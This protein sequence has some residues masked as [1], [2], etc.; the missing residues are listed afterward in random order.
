MAIPQ[1]V[2]GVSDLDGLNLDDPKRPAI[3]LLQTR[4]SENVPG[5]L[6]ASARRGAIRRGRHN[7]RGDEINHRATRLDKIRNFGH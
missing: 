1:D 5:G 6:I 3:S 2:T 7:V 4:H